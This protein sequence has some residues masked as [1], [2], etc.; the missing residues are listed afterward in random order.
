MKRIETLLQPVGSR[1]GGHVL[2]LQVL[3]LQAEQAAA[4]G[5]AEKV[6]VRLGEHR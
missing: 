6:A 5:R 4:G 2:V 1:Q 3:C